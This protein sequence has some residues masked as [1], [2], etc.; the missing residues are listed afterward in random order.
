MN[1][2]IVAIIAH[3]SYSKA[4]PLSHVL[5]CTLKRGLLSN[6]ASYKV[7]NESPAKYLPGRH[8]IGG[9]VYR[10]RRSKRCELSHLLAPRDDSRINGTVLSIWSP[11]DGVAV[12]AVLPALPYST[13]ITGSFAVKLSPLP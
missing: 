10:T 4:S 11:T 3:G 7:C 12:A 2:S 13:T 9:A 6:E 5:H 8:E 1:V